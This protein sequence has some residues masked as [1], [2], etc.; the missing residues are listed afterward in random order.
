MR[1]RI[2]FSLKYANIPWN[3]QHVEKNT[4]DQ[5]ICLK[6]ID[7]FDIYDNVENN[8]IRQVT[9]T[10][11]FKKWTRSCVEQLKDQRANITNNEEKNLL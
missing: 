7:M 3:I 1:L 5:E 2:I 9:N 4:T 10:A 6:C 8:S 11:H